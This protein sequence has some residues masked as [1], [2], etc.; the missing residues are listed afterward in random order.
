M[1]RAEY[2]RAYRA[3]RGDAVRSVARGRY[4]RRK[5]AGL[6][7]RCGEVAADGQYCADHEQRIQA[8]QRTW[9]NRR[10]A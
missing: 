8:T 6:C 2:M 4:L 10:A 5:L 9:W 3:V 7:V 1:T